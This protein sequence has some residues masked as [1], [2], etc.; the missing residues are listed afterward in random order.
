MSL[1]L[2]NKKAKLENFDYLARKKLRVIWKIFH[3]IKLQNRENRSKND[4]CL[5]YKC[6]KVLELNPLVEDSCMYYLVIMS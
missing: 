6:I 5:T 4:S 3:S 2:N 1:S